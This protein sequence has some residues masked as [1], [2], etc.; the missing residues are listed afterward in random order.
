[1]TTTPQS[2]TVPYIATWSAEQR[3][4]TTLITDSRGIAELHEGPH[5]RDS[6]GVLWWHRTL[7]VGRGRP[8]Y[9]SVHPQR[10]Q[11]AM[12]R[13]LCQVCAGP[14]D[15]DERGVLWLLEEHRNSWA[16]WPSDALTTHPPVC[17][18]CAVEAVRRCPHL[19]SGYTAVR[20]GESEVFGVYGMRFRPGRLAPVEVG[21]DVVS[22]GAP[23]VRW[24]VAGQLV[25]ALDS[26]TVVD[27]QDEL[28]ARP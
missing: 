10:Q 2:S 6:H 9:G 26:C 4:K 22:Y 16:T 28:A 11:R 27:L 12:R 13:L 7:H 19:A 14:A 23:A 24:V 1:M 3:L 15:R 17:L 21:I 8:E 25:R 18:P 5:S 20:V